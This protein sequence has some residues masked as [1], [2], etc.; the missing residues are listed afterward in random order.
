MCLWI[1]SPMASDWTGVMQRRAR[2][3]QLGRVGLWSPTCALGG[4]L[5]QNGD[6]VRQ[7]F[8]WHGKPKAPVVE[9]LHKALLQDPLVKLL[10]YTPAPQS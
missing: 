5:L 4:L 1:G 3:G 7:G 6:W 9:S 2:V 8:A 10:I